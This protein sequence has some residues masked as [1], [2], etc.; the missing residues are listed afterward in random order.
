MC[1][2]SLMLLLL[3]LAGSVSAWETALASEGA[4]AIPAA[5]AERKV[6]R[7]IVGM[8]WIG[9]VGLY[10]GSCSIFTSLAPKLK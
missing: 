7:E 9:C 4:L 8:G 3:V 5:A 2:I 10:V 6:L 1:S